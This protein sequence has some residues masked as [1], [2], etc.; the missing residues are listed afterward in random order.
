MDIFTISLGV[1]S[2]LALFVMGICFLKISKQKKLISSLNEYKKKKNEELLV[3]LELATVDQLL[4]E[5]R[6][7]PVIPYILVRPYPEGFVMES[8]NIPPVVAAGILG[9]A[10]L[11]L[12]EDLRAKGLLN[13]SDDNDGYDGW[14]KP[15][16]EP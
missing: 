9:V 10:S 11:K 4:D 1:F 16:D 13:D 15:G 6:T 2:V 8:H 7:R 14:L 12:G 3:D 5:L